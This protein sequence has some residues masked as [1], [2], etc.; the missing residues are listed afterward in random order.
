MRA[1]LLLSLALGALGVTACAHVVTGPRFKDQ[2]PKGQTYFGEVFSP[3]HFTSA[4]PVKVPLG[5]DQGYFLVAAID[6][7]LYSYDIVQGKR[8]E[9]RPWAKLPKGVRGTPVFD[10][11]HKHL[12]LGTY[13]RK[14]YAL[15]M[16]SS[17]EHWAVPVD[18]YVQAPVA[19]IG[20]TAVVGTLRG[21]VYGLA[22]IDGSIQWQYKLGG[23]VYGQAGVHPDW[24]QRAVVSNSR[25]KLAILN[26]ATGDALAEFQADSGLHDGVAVTLID[27]APRLFFGT[28]KGEVQAWDV[29]ASGAPVRVWSQDAGGEVWATP[30]LAPRGT[31]S[32]GWDGVGVYVVTTNSRVLALQGDTGATLWERTLEPVDRLHATPLVVGDRMYLGSLNH[33]L[34]CLQREDGTTLWEYEAYGEFR[35]APILDADRIIAVSNDHFLYAL[36]WDTGEPLIGEKQIAT[37]PPVLDLTREVLGAG[38]IT[39]EAPLDDQVLQQEVTPVI[40]DLIA[41]LATGDAKALTPFL[42]E[43][44]QVRQST[45]AVAIQDNFRPYVLQQHEV[46]TVIPASAGDL[47]AIVNVQGLQEGQPIRMVLTLRLLKDASQTPVWRVEPS[48]LK[49]ENVLQVPVVRN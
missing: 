2:I 13:D 33:H 36:T 39:A 9:K 4:S 5:N 19:L 38:G 28:D 18:G 32:A 41:A 11:S 49:P 17:A 3:V 30:A 31:G 44:D 34:Y 15:D 45:F 23:E 35:T 40:N 43:N 12:I 14:V 37:A 6:G 26:T 27:G 46:R 42:A 20:Q 10:P 25:G 24:P 29:P 8:R 21:T 48:A 47:V 16:H 1:L 22:S 7:S